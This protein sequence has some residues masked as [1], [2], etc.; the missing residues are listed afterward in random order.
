MK[1][2]L[3][4]IYD[5]YLK[6]KSISYGKKRKKETIRG[7]VIH[8]TGNQGDSAKN[9]VI[10]FSKQGGNTRAAGAHFFI[11][12]TGYI[13]KSIPMELTAWSVGNPSGCYKVGQYGHILNNSNTVSIELCDIMDKAPSTAMLESLD[14]VV[15][16]IKKYCPN[17]DIICRHYDVVQKD[18]PHRYVADVEA[19][20]K[21][22]KRL[23]D[24]IR[25]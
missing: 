16:H 3:K 15:R 1:K 19:W 22:Q 25:G 4:K 2:I 10:F 5:F 13:G 12:Q 14:K 23:Y 8:N 24:Q 11:D 17:V 6:A 18:C 20:K 7:I 9:N 21:L